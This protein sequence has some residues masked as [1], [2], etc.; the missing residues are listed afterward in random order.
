MLIFVVAVASGHQLKELI[1]LMHPLAR[2]FALASSRLDTFPE[3][4]ETWLGFTKTG[5]S[6][7]G[8]G[9]KFATSETKESQLNAAP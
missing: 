1:E 8:L 3:V 5:N 9:K 6:G 4:R 2:L 7:R